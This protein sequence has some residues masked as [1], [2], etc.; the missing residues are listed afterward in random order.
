MSRWETTRAHDGDRGKTIDGNRPHRAG[1][2]WPRRHRRSDRI[3]PRI[4]LNTTT[5]MARVDWGEFEYDGHG[6]LYNG[7]ARMPPDQLPS[8]LLTAD[9][10][11]R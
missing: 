4:L 3:P 9:G 2:P 10:D 6:L 7:H 1:S 8:F 5:T 11:D